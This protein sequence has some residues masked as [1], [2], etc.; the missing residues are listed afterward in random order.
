[1]LTIIVIVLLL[2]ILFGVFGANGP[3]PNPGRYGWSPAGLL[4]VILVLWLLFGG[5]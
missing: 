3:W 5:R 2:C 4:L 1:M